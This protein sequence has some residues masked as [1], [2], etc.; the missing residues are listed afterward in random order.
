[1][2]YEKPISLKEDRPQ[3]ITASY[4]NSLLARRHDRPQNPPLATYTNGTNRQSG[5]GVPPVF[6]Q[7]VKP[8]KES[9]VVAPVIPPPVENVPL[10]ISDSPEVN[11][12]I[13][14]QV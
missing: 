6:T 3:T 8:L 2:T 9:N 14:H 7:A 12:A 11:E 10:Y 1:M 4:D 5:A 13:E